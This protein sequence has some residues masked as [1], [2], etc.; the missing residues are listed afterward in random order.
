M[1]RVK[2]DD[3]PEINA[4]PFACI[5]ESYDFDDSENAKQGLCGYCVCDSIVLKV[6]SISTYK[7]FVGYLEVR[8]IF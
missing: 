1:L 4:S 3:G 7:D 5:Y 2:Q 6:V 8:N